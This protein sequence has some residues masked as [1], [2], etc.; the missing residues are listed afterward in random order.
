MGVHDE[1]EYSWL[2]DEKSL[3]RAAI[4]NGKTVIGVCLG[5]QLIADALGAK[6]YPGPEKEIGWLPVEFTEQARQPGVFPFL[7]ERLTVFQWHSDTFDLPQ[8]AVHLARS[9][10][11]ENQAFLYGKR[12]LALQFHLE[13]TPD[14]V[15]ELARECRAEI[16]PARYV[17]DLKT[18]LSADT[19]VLRR[20][21]AVLGRM[22]TR[23]C[24]TVVES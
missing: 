13:A 12:T 11:V 19:D 20:M 5:A 1:R 2:S 21:Y 16:R 4:I 24:D 18:I 10:A 22:L 3:I 8:G 6:V 23:L 14:G 17:Q 7:P 15:I 9:D